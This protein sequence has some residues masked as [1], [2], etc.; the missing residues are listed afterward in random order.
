MSALVRAKGTEQ[1]FFSLGDVA[2]VVGIGWPAIEL[3]DKF[4][5][6]IGY[7]PQ[8]DLPANPLDLI[9]YLP[10]TVVWPA[11]ESEYEAMPFKAHSPLAMKLLKHTDL[12]C[13]CL[14]PKTGSQPVAAPPASSSSGPL[15]PVPHKLK[16][17]CIAAVPT[18]KPEPLLKVAARGAFGQMGIGRLK[19]LAKHLKIAVYPGDKLIDILVRLLRFILAPLDEEVL[20]EVLALREFK[21][22]P[23][24]DILQA[25]EIVEQFDKWDQAEI[26][27]D[28]KKS[29]EHKEERKEYKAT[30]K[31]MRKD[32]RERALANKKM[33]C[34]KRGRYKNPLTKEERQRL[35]T[36]VVPGFLR[37]DDVQSMAPPGC[38][39]WHDE[40]CGRWQVTLD[41]YTKSRSWLK[42]GHT[43]SAYLVL[44][45]AWERFMELYGL[46]DCPVN[47]LLEKAA[48][49][50]KSAK[51]KLAVSKGVAADSGSGTAAGSA[52]AS[53]SGTA[54]GSATGSATALVSL[55]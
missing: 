36:N 34:K 21:K 30:L 53:V 44:A 32:F 18:S 43:E 38:K 13:K 3:K 37:S 35:P 31:D 40:F 12:E 26:E 42:Y 29:K 8:K 1:W 5:T 45:K 11:E 15:L 28:K 24:E 49:I 54:A 27:E 17:V 51:S 33:P 2:E 22:S 25:D 41:N 50:E 4:G 46:T 52:T 16:G 48:E 7:L 9:K 55:A 10:T 39:V 23:L 20:L 47:G 14:A 6:V 19:Q